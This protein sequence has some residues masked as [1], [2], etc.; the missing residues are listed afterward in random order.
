MKSDLLTIRSRVFQIALRGGRGIANFAGRNFFTR[1]LE[2]E[3]G[4]SNIFQS[5]KQLSVNT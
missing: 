2:S 4:H 3:E 1:W 5:K